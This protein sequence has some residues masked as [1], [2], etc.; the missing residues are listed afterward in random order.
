[1]AAVHDG[2]HFRARNACRP[3][4]SSDKVVHQDEGLA[5]QFA[6]LS[7]VLGSTFMTWLHLP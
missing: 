4:R 6:N 3:E 2:R 5:P 7:R 1:M